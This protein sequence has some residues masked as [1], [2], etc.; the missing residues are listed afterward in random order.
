ML[1]H[2]K[3]GCWWQTFE[4]DIIM[5]FFSFG[6]MLSPIAH[7]IQ[8]HICSIDGEKGCWLKFVTIL[9]SRGILA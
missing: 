7:V 2:G 6:D 8:S 1:K 5:W 4:I 3:Q 9:N